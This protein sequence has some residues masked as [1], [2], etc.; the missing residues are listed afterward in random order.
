MKQSILFLLFFSKISTS[1]FGQNIQPPTLFAAASAHAQ[2]N[3]FGTLDWS[4][5]ET[6]VAAFNPGVASQ[7]TQGFHQVFISIAT[8]IDETLENAG[9]LVKIFPNPTTGWVNIEAENAVRTRVFDISGKEMMA[10]TGFS[11]NPTLDLSQLSSGLFFLEILAEGQFSA[12]VFKLEVV[13]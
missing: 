12:R 7:L 10:A 13:K 6:L 9:F 11:Q 4:I 3:N 2:A 1:I 8:P 5:G